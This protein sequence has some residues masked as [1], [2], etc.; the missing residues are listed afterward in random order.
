[1]KPIISRYFIGVLLLK[2]VVIL[3]VAEALFRFESKSEP[4]V[5][6]VQESLVQDEQNKH[7]S[8]GVENDVYFEY[9]MD[10]ERTLL[11]VFGDSVKDVLAHH[12][13]RM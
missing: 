6:Q 13:V 4:D 3:P 9:G 12:M 7:K 11:D 10:D 5:Q 1:M 8:L 2:K